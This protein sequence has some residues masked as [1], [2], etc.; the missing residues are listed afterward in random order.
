MKGIIGKQAA[1]IK[2]IVPQMPRHHQNNPNCGQNP[3]LLIFKKIIF[4]K[5]VFLKKFPPEIISLKIFLRR[6]ILPGSSLPETSH[7]VSS[8]SPPHIKLLS[9]Y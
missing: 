2:K 9:A 4:S 3:K 5:I 6:M 7:S 1:Y 8:L